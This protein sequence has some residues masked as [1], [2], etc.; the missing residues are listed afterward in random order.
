MRAGLP[1]RSLTALIALLGYCSG[2]MARAA[3]VS[4]TY[5]YSIAPVRS[6]KRLTALR[7]QLKF[8]CDAGGERT[9]ILPIDD[10]DGH[11]HLADLV[12]SGAQSTSSGADKLHLRLP[13]GAEV[14]ISYDLLPGADKDPETQSRAPIIRDDWFAVHGESALIVPEGHESDGATVRYASA[15][16]GWTL[17]SNLDDAVTTIADVRDTMFVGGARYREMRRH[18]A[19]ANLRLVHPPEFTQSAAAALDDI[20]RIDAAERV[21]WH[22]KGEPFFVAVVPLADDVEYEGRGILVG[23]VLFLGA[24][25][26]KD[27]WLHLLA[28]EH[29]HTWISRRI[30]GFPVDDSD[31]EAWLNEGFTEA[32]AGRV[33]LRSRLWSAEQ[34]LADQ[35]MALLRYGTSP[36]R[37]APNARI[38]TDRNRDPDVN[39]LPYDRGSL[40]AVLWDWAIRRRTSGHLGLVD[41]LL[42][43]AEQASRNARVGVHVSADR[44]F[45]AV[46]RLLTGI[47]FTDDIARYV[48]RGDPIVLPSDAFGPCA[49]VVSV[50]QA[51]FDRGFDIQATQRAHG[52]ITGL[53]AGGP[54]E[55]AGLHEGD[56]VAI[57]EIPSHDSQ[58]ALSYTVIDAAGGRHPVT[59][60]PEGLGRVT[61]QQIRLKPVAASLEPRCAISLARP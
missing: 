23:F 5:A 39:K 43:M 30:G 15:P 37:T 32:L 55:R 26:P 52:R 38:G 50:T 53:E 31:L 7:V 4:P 49:A 35:N 44:L 9:L 57:D 2:G 17:T 46:A 56:R 19:G 59:Y 60:L 11:P 3:E 21:L 33:L 42:A 12:V 10:A 41:V 24:H 45:P 22:A 47:D 61:F 25:V 48:D 40:L 13:P 28:H 34:F 58:K 20:A 18:E 51:E 36:V 14:T 27:V 29:M 54:A 6:D 16:D 8:R 1:F